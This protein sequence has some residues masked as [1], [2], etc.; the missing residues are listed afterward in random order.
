MLMI[1]RNWSLRKIKYIK[2]K[3][4]RKNVV[5]VSVSAVLNTLVVNQT[6]KLKKGWVYKM[7]N[8]IVAMHNWIVK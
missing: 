1:N 2:R 4:N 3:L 8:R 7:K 6:S 5:Y